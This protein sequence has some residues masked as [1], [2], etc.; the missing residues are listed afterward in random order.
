MQ[1][2]WTRKSELDIEHSHDTFIKH[3]AVGS[4]KNE[5]SIYAILGPKFL[6]Y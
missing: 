3:L 5:I 1:I 4:G 6:L 2:I